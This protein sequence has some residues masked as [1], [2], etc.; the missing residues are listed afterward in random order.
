MRDLRSRSTNERQTSLNDIWQ[1]AGSRSSRSPTST[2]TPARSRPKSMPDSGR[3]R[4]RKGEEDYVSDG[5]SLADQGE[6]IDDVKLQNFNNLKV[7]KVKPGCFHCFFFW[8]F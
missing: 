2:S 6:R 7:P 8:L 4:R 5:E 3:R 1:G